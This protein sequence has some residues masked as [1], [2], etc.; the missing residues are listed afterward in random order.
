MI[1]LPSA[2]TSEM[3]RSIF[4][5]MYVSVIPVSVCPP[6]NALDNWFPGILLL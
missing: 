3:T 1:V 5:Q 4:L 2:K 6:V